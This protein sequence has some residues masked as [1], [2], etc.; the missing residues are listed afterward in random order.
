MV[1]S[2]NAGIGHKVD[3]QPSVIGVYDGSIKSATPWRGTGIAVPVFSLRSQSSVG[4]GEFMDIKSLVD[5]CSTTGQSLSIS[6][7]SQLSLLSWY[8][9]SRY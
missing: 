6:M 2:Y 7:L 9:V 1:L 5:F 4:C 3:I 8:H